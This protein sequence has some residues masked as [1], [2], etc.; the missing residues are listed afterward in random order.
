M[1]EKSLVNDEAETLGAGAA[2][3]EL[4]LE[5]LEVELEL[6][7]ELPQADTATPA[8]IASATNPALLLSKCTLTSSF[9]GAQQRHRPATTRGRSSGCRTNRF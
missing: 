9:S 5:L 4:A 3:D 7:D 6:E 2:A 1:A 8:V